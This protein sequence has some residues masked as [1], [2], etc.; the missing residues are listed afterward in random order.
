[1]HG[2]GPVVGEEDLNKPL[3]VRN[4][5]KEDARVGVRSYDLK[6]KTY[7]SLFVSPK[8][9][10]DMTSELTPIRKFSVFW[11]QQLVTDTIIDDTVADPFPFEVTGGGI[12]I[13]YSKEKPHWSRVL[14]AEA[15]V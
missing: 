6:T 8:I 3:T 14:E 11:H 5:W 10:T 2:D 7:N 12:T 13:K 4:E 9:L 1:M 15:Q